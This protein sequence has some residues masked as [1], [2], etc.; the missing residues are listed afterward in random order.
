[1]VVLDHDNQWGEEKRYWEEEHLRQIEQQGQYEVTWRL[2]EAW[3]P[4]HV[5]EGKMLL[6]RLLTLEVLTA[7][8]AP[9]CPAKSALH[10]IVPTITRRVLPTF[11]TVAC[12]V[13]TERS[14]FDR[15]LV[16]VVLSTGVHL[17]ETLLNL[18]NAD[19]VFALLINARKAIV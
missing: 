1:M 12:K 7:D 8:P 11:G 5:V 14:T 18:L 10:P 15:I 17:N 2:G 9:A 3:T 19:T 6:D 4:K 16:F 13:G